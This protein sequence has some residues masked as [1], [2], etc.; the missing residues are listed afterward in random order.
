MVSN[1]RGHPPSI[2]CK[3]RH[4]LHKQPSILHEQP[5]I[6]CKLRP[7]GEVY[8]I[9]LIGLLF[10]GLLTPACPN[11]SPPPGKPPEKETS[12]LETP[13]PPPPPRQKPELSFSLRVHEL[14]GAVSEL[15]LK[16]EAEFEIEP[17]QRIEVVANQKLADF[18]VRLMDAQERVLPSDEEIFFAAHATTVNIQ[19]LSPLKP[20]NSLVLLVDSQLSHK[21]S[22]TH[23]DNYD[24]FR[25]SFKVRGEPEKPAE[26]PKTPSQKPKK[27][28][29]KKTKR[30]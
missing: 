15:L 28:T 8:I 21:I 7:K 5:S 6:L 14:S 9:Y 29:P 4:I 23:G 30:K 25:A 16:P 10:W 2:L 24:D 19:L 27:S 11:T 3:P 22:N 13:P 20:A 1:K 17:A 26:K 12:S 18:R